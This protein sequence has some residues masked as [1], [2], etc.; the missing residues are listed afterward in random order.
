MGT[1]TLSTSSGSRAQPAY[2][3]NC[4]EGFDVLLRPVFA[5]DF[6]GPNPTD[7]AKAGSKHHIITDAQGIPRAALLTRANVHDVTQALSLVETIPPVKGKGC[8]PRRRPAQLHGDRGYDSESLRKQLR[9]RH[10]LPVLAN[11]GE[12]NGSGLGAYRWVVERTLSWLR[13]RYERR[14]H[15]H[16]AFLTIGCLINCSRLLFQ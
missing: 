7:R 6:T 10:I 9:Y 8:R 15:I 2:G 14:P 13:I 16:E 5:R 1:S 4:G 11:R 3:S 12:P